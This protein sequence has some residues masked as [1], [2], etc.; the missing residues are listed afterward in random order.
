MRMCIA[1]ALLVGLAS[2]AS[3]TIGA[4]HSGQ[5][6]GTWEGS[7][8]FVVGQGLHVPPQNSSQT[9]RITI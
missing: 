5:L 2:P 6:E 7:L 9:Y 4:V 3:Q 1:F 8:E